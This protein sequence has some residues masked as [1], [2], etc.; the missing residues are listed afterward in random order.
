MKGFR[1]LLKL[2]LAEQDA[3]TARKSQER[4]G[5]R[6]SELDERIGGAQAKVD[7]SKAKSEEIATAR[8]ALEGDAADLEETRKKYHTQLMEA[9]TNEVYRTLL[10]EIEAAAERISEKESAIL[11]LMEKDE[12]IQA[13]LTEAQTELTTAQAETNEELA[14]LRGQV[15]ELEVVRLAAQEKVDVARE[16]VPANFLRGYDRI[17]AS[18][19]GKALAEVEAS[20]C[21][22]CRVSV[23]PQVWVDLLKMQQLHYCPGC[24]RMLYRR[25]NLEGLV[26]PEQL[27]KDAGDDGASNDEP[28]ATSDA[29]AGED[30]P[31]P[32]GAG[33]N[34]A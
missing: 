12:G 21:L 31:A 18:R 16:D 23:R 1:E 15:D 17:S 7:Q 26:P 14:D 6:I 32:A 34:G 13:T 5:R 20:N 3:W 33:G 30:S 10:A 28:E 9:K 11:E 22:A 29:P 27:K 8:R 4:L 25:E 24:G 19:D 2:H